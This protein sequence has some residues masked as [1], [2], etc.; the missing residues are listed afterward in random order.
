MTSQS[1]RKSHDLHSISSQDFTAPQDFTASQDFSIYYGV[2]F[3]SASIIQ[4]TLLA[5]NPWSFRVSLSTPHLHLP[6]HQPWWTMSNMSD[7]PLSR[8][9]APL[10]ED[11]NFL[12]IKIFITIYWL[13]NWD[14][15]WVATGRGTWS[16]FYHTFHSSGISV[17][18]HSCWQNHQGINFPLFFLPLSILFSP[19]LVFLLLPRSFF[20]SASELKLI[21]SF[22]KAS[23]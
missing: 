22:Q 13:F 19:H 15:L 4:S 1:I 5:S 10:L 8:H 20:R 2:Y 16:V 7:S 11:S 14:Q 6:Q 17:F 9:V 18:S 21:F 23:F 3:A 12:A